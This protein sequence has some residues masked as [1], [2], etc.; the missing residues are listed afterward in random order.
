MPKP[1]AKKSEVDDFVE[2]NITHAEVYAAAR[3]SFDF[4]TGIVDGQNPEAKV[5]DQIWAARTLLEYAVRTPD[6][7]GQL[8]DAA[9]LAS[10]EDLELI[11]TVLE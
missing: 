5:V 4:L 3:R 6:F 9:G 11:A 8:A 2:Q 7:F 10:P 1:R